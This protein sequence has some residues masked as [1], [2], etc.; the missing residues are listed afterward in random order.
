MVKKTFESKGLEYVSELAIKNIEDFRKILEWN[1][2]NKILVYRMSS[3][4]FPCLGFYKIKD[5]PN[6]EKIS[7]K[8]KECGDFSI[9]NSILLSHKIIL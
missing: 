7:K 1:L 8:L 3:D 9:K 2:K 4:M 6:Y 5:L